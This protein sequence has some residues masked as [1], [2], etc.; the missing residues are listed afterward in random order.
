[1]NITAKKQRPKVAR[2]L[3]IASFVFAEQDFAVVSIEEIAKRANVARGTVYNH[4]RTKEN[5]YNQVLTER[6]GSLMYKLSQVIEQDQ[7]PQK[8]L[9]RCVVH[10]FMFFIK[11]PNLLILW[12]RETLRRLS[13]H[14]GNGSE[15]D[16]SK[17]DSVAYHQKKLILLIERVLKDGI[18]RGVFLSGDSTTIANIFLGAV[19]GL[20]NAHKGKHVNS[21][22]VENAKLDLVSFI[23]GS[24]VSARAGGAQ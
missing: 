15:G 21:E 16:M 12:Q 7:N 2:I 1:M 17:F 10:P 6:L 20:A 24:L 22:A 13:T 18:R 23:R 9:E 19:I 14:M 5:L 11:Y 4:F 3:E 8:N